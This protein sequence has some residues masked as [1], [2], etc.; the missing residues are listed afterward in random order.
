MKI[1]LKR[2]KQ[3]VILV[4]IAITLVFIFGQS[5]L[6]IPKSVENSDGFANKIDTLFEPELIPQPQ[7]PSTDNS[8]SNDSGTEP[9]TP[10]T[11]EGNPGGEVPPEDAPG[12]SGSEDTSGGD[13]GT[14][15]PGGDGEENTPGTEDNVDTPDGDE[16]EDIPEEEPEIIYV[17]KPRP[18]IDYIIANV[19]KVAHFV[20]HGILGLEV[21]LLMF[22]IEKDAQKKRKVFPIGVKLFILSLNIG[23]L[24]ALF[25]E[26][27]QILSG[28]GPD[29]RDIWLDIAG[30]AT[31]TALMFVIF[32]LV[33]SIIFLA[34]TMK[35]SELSA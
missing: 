32:S 3:I 33:K 29:V 12:G 7:E 10:G 18:V 27:I 5:M 35:N 23:I 34:K 11:S 17:A 26:S 30:Y 8:G 25:D 4:I 2:K 20:E 16:T 28:R 15:P 6:P 1:N 19:R 24:A 14:E 31:F 9:E 22:F 21:F 13:V